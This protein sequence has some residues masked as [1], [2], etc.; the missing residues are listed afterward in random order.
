MDKE[1]ITKIRNDF[2]ILKQKINGNRLAYLDNAATM[3]M[4]VPILHKINSFYQTSYA[5]VHRS[6]DTLGLC[7]YNMFWNL[8]LKHSEC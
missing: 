7:E 2:P 3:Q 4:P 5:N 8:A 6:V 1:A